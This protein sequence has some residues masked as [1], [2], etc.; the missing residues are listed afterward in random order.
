[1]V[2]RTSQA[3]NVIKLDYFL[4]REYMLGDRF[5]AK[6]S[7]WR[8]RHLSLASVPFLGVSPADWWNGEDQCWW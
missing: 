6:F 3:F 7:P 2:L 4:E 8:L 5:M 1:M